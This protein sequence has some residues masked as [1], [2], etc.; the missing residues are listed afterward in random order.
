MREHVLPPKVRRRFVA[1]A[2]GDH[3]GPIFPDQAKEM[4]L[5]GHDQF[6]VADLT[7]VTISNGFAY[8]T[9]ILDAWSCR[10]VGYAIGRSIDAR[11]ASAALRAAI[12][13]RQPPPGCVHHSDRGSQYAAEADRKLLAVH[14]TV[15]CMS[16][17]GNLRIGECR[18]LRHDGMSLKLVRPDLTL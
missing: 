16:R 13:S 14:R 12:T 9:V 18:R 1:T 8:V 3:D 7:C 15:G 10:V 4:A 2:D 17:R 11:L 6:S 5:A